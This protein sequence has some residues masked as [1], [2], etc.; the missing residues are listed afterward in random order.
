MCQDKLDKII[1]A[2]NKIFESNGDLLVALYG[3]VHEYLGMN[4]DWSTE[5]MVV[6]TIYDYLEDILAELPS[7]FDGVDVTPVVS[8]L[9]T[10]NIT[11]QKLDT[12]TLKIFH[13]IV[14]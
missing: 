9:F 13:R 4:I 3:K 7:G 12:P 8:E 1:A 2:L 6:I 10:V 14:A 11:R 5:G